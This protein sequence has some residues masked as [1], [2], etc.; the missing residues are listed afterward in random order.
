MSPL[1]TENH[2]VC[3]LQ[4]P[5]GEP[6]CNVD[7]Y[8]EPGKPPA[9]P[10]MPPQAPNWPAAVQIALNKAVATTHLVSGH[11]AFWCCDEHARMGIERGQHLPP[12]PK[13]VAPA[14]EADLNAAKRGMK[15][16]ENMREGA[17]PS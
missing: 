8:Y 1:T 2:F 7:F 13:K 14:T 3:Q 10:G 9:M 16:V 5:D 17:K 12:M 6:D 4:K 15:V 11:T